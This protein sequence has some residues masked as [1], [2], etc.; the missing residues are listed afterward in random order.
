M[1]HRTFTRWTLWSFCAASFA[2]GCTTS[3]EPQASS[4]SAGSVELA[5]EAVDSVELDSVDYVITGGDIEPMSGTIDTSAPGA[6]A[7]VEV[8]GLPPGDG[9]TV[10]ME[11]TSEDGQTSCKGSAD[12]SVVAGQATDVMVILSC[13]RPPMLGGVRANGKFNQCAQLTKV[14]VAPLQTSIG[15]DIDV[16][17]AAADAEGDAITYEWTATGGSFAD[18]AAAAT[19]YTCTDPGMQEVTVTASDDDFE[20]CDDSWTVSVN[21]VGE[22]YLT[23]LHNNDGESKVINAGPAVQEDFGGAARFRTLLDQLRDAAVPP[24]DAAGGPIL[25]SSGDN[26]LASPEFNVSL[27]SGVPFFDT[28]SIE[29]LGYDALSL[30]N[31]DFDFGPDIL[32]DFIDG[33]VEPPVYVCA[34]ADFSLESRLQAYVAQGVILPTNVVDVDGVAVGVIGVITPNL[35]SISSPRNVVISDNLVNIVQGQVDALEELG[36]KV[37]ILAGHLQ[38]INEDLALAAQIRGVDAIIAGGGDELLANEGDLLVPE[39]DGSLPE[40][41]GPYPTIALDADGNEIPVVTTNG[42]YKYI[43]QLVL[44]FNGEGEVVA[45]DRA[46]SGPRRVV[47]DD[48]GGTMPCNDTVVPDAEMQTRVVDPVQAGVQELQD[49]VIAQS[50]VALDGRRSSVRFVETNEGNLI[51]DSQLWAGGQLAPEFGL[52]T[53]D[54]A[55][56]NGGGIRN[57]SIIPAGPITV[58]DTFSMV[59][60]PN[61]V[62]IFPSIARSQFK[63]I[64]EH[65][66]SRAEDPEN[67]GTGRFAQIAGF[68]FTWNPEGT[69]QEVD[70]EGNV[71][72]AGSRVVQ[73]T[74]D[75]GTDPRPKRRRHRWRPDLT[76]HDRLPRPRRRRLSLPRCNVHDPRRELPARAPDL[77]RNRARGRDHRRAV[78]RGRR[79]PHRPAVGGQDLTPKT[80]KSQVTAWGTRSPSKSAEI[81]S[82]YRAHRE[83]QASR[84][85]C[86]SRVTPVVTYCTVLIAIVMR[87][88]AP[89]D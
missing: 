34:N 72:Q 3:T 13:K 36:V 27:T 21:C 67:S 80:L 8:F 74:L 31:H 20:Y 14:S 61:F 83:N 79:R 17:A 50:Q 76:G 44:I 81:T 86:R 53:P 37:I 23:I 5:L 85:A 59:P 30:G 19:S 41:E 63:E 10:T 39:S 6:T 64:V 38:G 65:A 28:I 87:I 1:L 2:V 78:P 24:G 48:C 18:D 45:I 35:P 75:D 55:I 47:T 51:A 32:A 4:G 15:A 82:A 16:S 68:S 43:G 52:E 54:V 46:Q 9:Y 12:F 60:F 49:T 70:D 77:H 57:D 89:S 22:F 66:V 58:F 84:W 42:N 88:A 25:I 40:I 26:F 29:L 7:S 73:V 69:A 62:V 11:A 33:Y 56:Q 71:T